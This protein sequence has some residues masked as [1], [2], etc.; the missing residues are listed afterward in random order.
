MS[1]LNAE[2]SPASALA[3]LLA[4]KAITPANAK[5]PAFEFSMGFNKSAASLAATRLLDKK[6]AKTIKEEESLASTIYYAG[7]AP[8]AFAVLRNTHLISGFSEWLLVKTLLENGHEKAALRLLKKG[9]LSDKGSINAVRTS[10]SS[11]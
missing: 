5:R 4:A 9:T 1:S 3:A 8:L 10:T 6:E 11:P 2:S 7:K